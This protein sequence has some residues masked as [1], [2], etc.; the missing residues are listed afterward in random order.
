MT[1]HFQRS[2]RLINQGRYDLAE[3]E[4][5]QVLRDDPYKYPELRLI[6]G[7]ELCS[8]AIGRLAYRSARLNRDFGYTNQWCGVNLLPNSP[9]L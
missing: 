9:G 3:K 8:T 1:D 6:L 2:Q 7:L 5:Q 4:L